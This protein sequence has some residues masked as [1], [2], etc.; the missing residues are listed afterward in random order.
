MKYLLSVL[1]ALS[2]VLPLKAQLDDKCMYLY[3][4]DGEI[5]MLFTSEIEKISHSDIDINDIQQDK[6]VTMEIQTVDKLYKIPLNTIDKI[7]FEA[8][9]TLYQDDVRLIDEKW[10][11]YIVEINDLDITLSNNIPSDVLPSPGEVIF[12]PE[13]IGPFDN[14]FAARV[15]K[16]EKT[17]NNIILTCEDVDLSDIFKFMVSKGKVDLM[18]DVDSRASNGSSD[19]DISRNTLEVGINGEGEYYVN[20]KDLSVFITPEITTEYETIINDSKEYISTITNINLTGRVE[21]Q[22]KA[23]SDLS[24]D[25]NVM[26]SRLIPIPQVPGFYF[27]IELG[28]FLD[29]SGQIEADMTVP[30]VAAGKVGYVRQGKEVVERIN[31]WESNIG[32]FD[33]NIQLSGEV[34][35]GLF[36]DVTTIMIKRNLASLT[37]GGKVGPY[38]KGNIFLADLTGGNSIYNDLKN[39]KLELTLDGRFNAEWFFFNHKATVDELNVNLSRKLNEWYAVPLFSNYNYS[40]FPQ[41]GG[42]GINLHAD[43]ERNLLFPVKLGWSLYAKDDDDYPDKQEYNSQIYRLFDD[44]NQN[45]IEQSFDG[46]SYGARYKAYPIIN[47]FF[48]DIRA[49]EGIDVKIDPYVKTLDADI[50]TYNATLYG[51]VEGVNNLI[52]PRVGFCYSTSDDCLEGTYVEAEL[53]HD[54]YREVKELSPGTTY[55]YRAWV[56]AEGKYFYGEQKTFST[57]NDLTSNKNIP[58]LYVQWRK[59]PA[60]KCD[61][62]VTG[63]PVYE[64]GMDRV[65]FYFE[66]VEEAEGRDEESITFIYDSFDWDLT[67]EGNYVIHDVEFIIRK[68]E[69]YSYSFENGIFSTVI[70]FKVQPYNLLPEDP[71]LFGSVTV[72]CKPSMHYDHTDMIKNDGW[73]ARLCFNTEGV[74]AYAFAMPNLEIA[75]VGYSNPK[76][77]VDEEEIKGEKITDGMGYYHSHW[78]TGIPGPGSTWGLY[79][80]TDYTWE[81]YVV[82]GTV[83]GVTYGYVSRVF[84]I[85]YNPL[86]E[87]ERNNNVILTD[88]PK[89]HAEFR[90]N[91][92][93]TLQDGKYSYSTITEMYYPDTDIRVDV[94]YPDWTITTETS[95]TPANF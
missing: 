46:L 37:L 76:H 68:P 48:Q 87:D 73:C 25:K 74:F 70:P 29:I 56:F 88:I 13:Y 34:G 17:S 85:D 26:F 39:S 35:A 21:Y 54:F 38:L 28:S 89:V 55:T 23:E 36:L 30:F 63:L 92:T 12:A 11:G 62:E 14:G 45:G 51:Q 19:N 31:T 10:T 75:N 72:S 80:N 61:I 42:S 94:P 59:Y 65:H 43:L 22:L 20:Y 53:G 77:Y 90:R 7:E 49:D 50:D 24:P 5:L 66:T 67:P 58:E 52:N 95:T 3:K 4:N 15:S 69:L 33:P 71:K 27:L 8:P 82:I 40:L 44:W 78:H 79:E 86:Q 1:F 60:F 83:R 93:F 41:Y 32:D 47:L 91:Y 64:T 2:F 9:A 18:N 57:Y 16:I 6:V 81:D 84:R